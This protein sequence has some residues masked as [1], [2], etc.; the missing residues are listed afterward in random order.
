M[1]GA[2]RR[3]TMGSIMK[4]GAFPTPGLQPQEWLEL[5]VLSVAA[6]VLGSLDQ[7]TRGPSLTAMALTYL[8]T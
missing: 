7:C 8:F 1:A 2:G 6:I 5:I 4:D 3:G